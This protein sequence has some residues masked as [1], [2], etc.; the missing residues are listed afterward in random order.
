MGTMAA[1]LLGLGPAAG[2]ATQV[3]AAACAVLA[4]VVVLSG[5]GALKQHAV[6]RTQV[7][8]RAS[9]YSLFDPSKEMV[10][11]H[12]MPSQHC[13]CQASDA[14]LACRHHT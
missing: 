9:K 7:M 4:R 12:L 1:V 3:R 5:R 6:A 8:G 2:I 13:P 10:R 14:A 11:D